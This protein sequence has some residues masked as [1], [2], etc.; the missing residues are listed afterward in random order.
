M[1]ILTGQQMWSLSPTQVQRSFPDLYRNWRNSGNRVWDPIAQNSNQFRSFADIEREKQAWNFLAGQLMNQQLQNQFGPFLP[2]PGSTPSV[3]G[4]N[5][6]NKEIE[7]HIQ[8]LDQALQVGDLMAAYDAAEDALNLLS[9]ICSILGQQLGFGGSFRSGLS[10]EVFDL[11]RILAPAIAEMDMSGGAEPDWMLELCRMVDTMTGKDN[12]VLES[13]LWND[14][15]TWYLG[16]LKNYAVQEY[17]TKGDIA[18]LRVAQR[19]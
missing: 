5:L 15:P 1:L 16:Q 18:G 12:S 7:A 19:L 11:A 8:K 17:L 2:L 13:F 4:F 6:G 3:V 9:R 14:I 10:R